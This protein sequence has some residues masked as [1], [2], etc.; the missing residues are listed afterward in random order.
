M[1]KANLAKKKASP[2]SKYWKTKADEE[3]SK[4]IRAVGYCERCRGT[5]K[6]DA[7]HIITR[8]RLRYRHDLSNGVCLCV[9]C[10]RFNPDISPHIDSYGA[11]KFIAWLKVERP[12]QYEW[13]QANKDN[14]QLSDKTY[15]QAYEELR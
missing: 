2:N 5:G 4:Q 12:G 14:K 8:T 3:W 9:Q 11:E 1:A 6:L 15:R 10:H 7:H 13:Y